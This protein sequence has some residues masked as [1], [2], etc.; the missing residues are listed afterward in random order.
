MIELRR[1]IRKL[2]TEIYELSPED[3]KKLS[4]MDKY[5]QLNPN[6]RRAVGLQSKEEIVYDRSVLQAYQKKLRA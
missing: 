4:S 2:I 6:L 3:E 1:I 5:D